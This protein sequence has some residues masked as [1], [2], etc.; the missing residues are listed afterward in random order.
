MSRRGL[1]QFSLCREK[2]WRKLGVRMSFR[3][4][5]CFFTSIAVALVCLPS[6]TF[7]Q[8]KDIADLAN[9]MENR[10][11][12]SLRKYRVLQEEIAAE[13]VP[14]VQLINELENQAIEMRGQ[15]R[16]IRSGEERAREELRSQRSLTGDLRTQNDYV[17]G[18]FAQYLNTFEGR[19]NIAEDQRL[20]A[21]LEPFREA[22][23]L[24]GTGTQEA[25]EKRTEAVEICLQR[26]ALISG[27]YSFDGQ[28]IDRAGKFS[29]VM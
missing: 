5:F 13:K 15:M 23:E 17:S 22:I 25:R 4:L 16:S 14:L 3:N 11:E 1:P 29:K 18:L 7:G 12:E 27:G 8:V 9:Q 6:A 19:L 2:F 10:V 28:A 26:L 24:A 20:S 21:L